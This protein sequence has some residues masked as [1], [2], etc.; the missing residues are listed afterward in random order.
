[1]PQRIAV[2]GA[3]VLGLA[4]AQ[5]LSR[6]GA[7]VTVFDKGFPGSGTSQ[8]SYAWVNANGKEPDIYHELNVRSIEEHKRWQTSHPA[9]PQW[10]LETGTLEWAADEATFRQLAQRAAKLATLNYPCEKH[11]RTALLRALPALRL[12]PRVQ[13]A[14]FF[15]S[16]CLLYPSLYIA[17]LLADLRASGGQ[18]VCNNEV[19]T[20]KESGRDVHLTLASGDEWRGDQ[21]V[22]ATG[23]WS[24]ELMSQCGLELAMTDSNRADPV[25]C[26]FLAQ[27]QPLPVSL[28]CNL[29]T[30]ELNVRPDGGGRLMLQA[31]D[32]DQHADPS[33]PASPDGL[34]GKE[35]LRRLR[36]LFHH[37]DG[38]RIER[39]ET[40]QRSRPADGLPALGYTSA[41]A[42]IYLMV[43]HSGMTL[44]PLLGRLVAEEMLSGTAS[45]MLSGFTPHRLLR[46]LSAVAKTAPAYLPA[47]Q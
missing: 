8:I 15:P 42:R 29:I 2:I 23:R 4:V 3:G 14:W 21:L 41:S 22:L 33:R 47:A 16:E 31:L 45:P 9:S 27:T 46:P 10:L 40:G 1:M 6:R 5:S 39:I 25:A 34:I 35:M 36:R 17:S 20:L 13:E 18:L 11:D 43:S 44:A 24:P 12:D 37:A 38:A 7:Q 26:S 30:P 19:T 28:N 32:L